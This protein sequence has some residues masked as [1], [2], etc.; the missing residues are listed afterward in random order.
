MGRFVADPYT[1][2]EKGKD[3]QKKAEEFRVN[4]TNIYD[5]INEMVSRDY[6]SPE[7]VAIA[8]KIEEKKEVLDEMASVIEQYGSFSINAGNKVLRNQDDIISAV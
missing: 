5:N 1:L 4:I 8:K 7:A 2:I 3:I 6:L